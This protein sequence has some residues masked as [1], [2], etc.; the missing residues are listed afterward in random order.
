MWPL[1]SVRLTRLL[2]AEALVADRDGDSIAPGR[3]SRQSGRSS[4][5]SPFRIGADSQIVATAMEKLQAGV[6][7]KLEGSAA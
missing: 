3:P 7:R 1:L 4:S 6:L 5:P 2:L